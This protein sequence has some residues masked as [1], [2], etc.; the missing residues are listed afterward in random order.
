MCACRIHWHIAR[1]DQG[2][3]PRC[4]RAVR[5]HRRR[6]LVLP[7]PLAGAAEPNLERYG[8]RIHPNSVI[9][10]MMLLTLAVSHVHFHR[11]ILS[12]PF[13][14][15]AR[16]PARPPAWALGLG[17]AG[18]PTACLPAP[19]ASRGSRRERGPLSAAARAGRPPSGRAAA[20][21]CQPWA[22]RRHAGWPARTTHRA[23]C[24]PQAPSSSSSS[25]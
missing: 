6:V 4:E 14:R 20:W 7:G 22:R 12:P 9:V 10:L 13:P 11:A 3:V 23:A 8:S 24:V 19:G 1:A 2:G 16:P 15:P 21:Q 17:P 5:S 25:R 18:Y